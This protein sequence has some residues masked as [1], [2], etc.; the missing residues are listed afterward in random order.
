[1]INAE[2][3]QPHFHLAGLHLGQVEDVVDHVE[4]EPPGFLDVLGIAFLLFVQCFQ[5]LQHFGEA[6]DAV[7]RRSQLVAH[8]GQKLAFEAVHFVKLHVEVCQLIDLVVELDVG[9][10]QL[11]VSFD[12][13]NEHLI[14]R[15]GEVFEFVV[16]VDVG[17]LIQVAA[18]H[19]IAHVAQVIERLDHDVFDDVIQ[20]DHRQKDRQNA[21]RQENCARL[22][23]SGPA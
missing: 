2:L 9:I 11:A 17:S 19:R 22:R 18:G 16:G 1:M 10:F 5:R 21:D 3:A 4:Q 15:V 13:V 23:D 6:N 7:Q 8:V 14:E 20:R 12:E